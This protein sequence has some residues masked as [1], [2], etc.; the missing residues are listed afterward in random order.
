MISSRI[1]GNMVIICVLVG[2]LAWSGS[3]YAVKP[4]PPGKQGGKFVVLGTGDGLDVRT[5]L[6]WQQAPGGAR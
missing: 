4:N 2:L 1:M 5:S 3:V 6:R